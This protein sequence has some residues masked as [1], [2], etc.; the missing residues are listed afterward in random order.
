MPFY[1]I[2]GAS[3]GLGYTWLKTLSADKSNIVI[4]TARTPEPVK[5]QLKADNITNVEVVKADVVDPT[6]LKQA[7][8]EVSKYTTS[9]DYLIVNAAWQNHETSSLTPLSFLDNDEMLRTE[10]QQYNETNVLGPMFA[11]NAFLPLV[12]KS[13]VKKIVVLSSGLGDYD[14]TRDAEVSFSVAY[15]AYK[16]ALNLIVLKYAIALKSEGVAILALSPGVINTRLTPPTEE[17][18]A[19][20]AVMFQKFQKLYPSWQGPFSAEESVAAQ[21]KVIEGLTLEQ[22]G[23]FLSHKGNKEWL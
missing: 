8:A 10:F 15:S 12:R 4:G 11:I 17:E 14:F 9:I 20:F 7:V 22:S 23:E 16:A 1:L 18:M 19:G 13:T 2:I 5:D 3:R 6:S 21:R